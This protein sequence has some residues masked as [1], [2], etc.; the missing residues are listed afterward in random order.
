MLVFLAEKCSRNNG[1]TKELS[2]YIQE[3]GALAEVETVSGRG[4]SRLLGVL[5]A[6]EGV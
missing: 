3:A 6:E 4:R 5:Q 1:G 2:G